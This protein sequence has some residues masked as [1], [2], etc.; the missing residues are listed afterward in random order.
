MFK[1][2]YVSVVGKPNAGKSTL[3]NKLVGFKVAITTPKP[4]TTRF[5]IKGIVTSKTSQ[6]VFIDTPG[7]HTPKHKMG[8]YMM[9]SVNTA[10]NNVD[11]IVYLVDATRP[12]IDFA[13][14]NIM[15]NIGSLN[16]SY[17]RISNISVLKDY[18]FPE[19]VYEG[20][21]KIDLSNNYINLNNKN[22][23]EA[24]EHFKKNKKYP[25][26]IKSD[27]FTIY[28]YLAVTATKSSP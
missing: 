23:A 13:N 4:Q 18:V 24:Q 16:L 2:G 15:K 27:T 10:I 12:K 11:I 1:S 5:N 20:L 17:N 9:Q 19:N 14:E 8:K 28:S 6:I 3:V 22:N 26:L 25:T 21:K 7:V